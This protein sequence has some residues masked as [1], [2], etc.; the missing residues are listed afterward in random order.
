MARIMVV[1]DEP[2]TAADLEQKLVA[3]GHSVTALVDTGEE[4]VA[5]SAEQTP[6][7]VLMDIRLRTAMDGIEAARLIRARS[8]VP[9]VFLTAFADPD[10][11]DRACEA[12]PFG[13]LLKPF[14]ER[15]VATAVQVA[16]TRA[17]SERAHVERERWMAAALRGA[18]EALI[19]VDERAVIRFI[20]E[21][22]EQLL[23]V[24]Q[25][26]VLGKDARD[27]VRFLPS[28][29]GDAQHP[30][31]AALQ[32]GRMT[33]APRRGLWV[34]GR[35]GPVRV[36]YSA[37]PIRATSGAH[38]GA[39]LVCHENA[40]TETAVGPELTDPLSTLPMRLSHEINNPLTYNLGALNLALRELD[41][42]RAVSA[43]PD[44]AGGPSA[45]G[46]EDQL[47]RIE[48]LLRSAQE[49]ATRIAAV[50]RELGSSSGSARQLAPLHPVELLDLAIGLSG[51]GATPQLRVTRQLNPAPLIR[52]DK[53]ELA[54]VLAFAMQHAVDALDPDS[55][56]TNTLDLVVDCD[57]RGW[58]EIRLVARGR[59]QS[60]TTPVQPREGTL[61]ESERSTS[62]GMSMAQHVIESRGGELSVHEQPDGRVLV[63]RLEPLSIETPPSEVDAEVEPRRGSVLVVDDEPMIGRI[64]EITLQ[65]EHD[66][67]VVS[68]ASSALALLERGDAFDVILCDLSMPGMDGRELYE[69]LR[70]TKPDVAARMIFMS[71]GA[72]AE[73]GARFLE[74]MAG[75]R[76]DKPFQTEQLLQMLRERVPAH[77]PRAAHAQR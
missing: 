76:I 53:W 63:L 23:Q 57:A 43:L 20:N 72:T 59:R 44:A 65:P 19:A 49:G 71:G 51:I 26:D 42:L 48:A 61:A 13:Y 68:S 2:I 60:S 14:T 11:V 8:D 62:I 36:A 25:A 70:A 32:N 50:V 1:E 27:V 6:D 12:Q 46:L 37:A 75:C 22:A 18:G 10:T 47:V 30:L 64:L 31:D 55:S 9:I 28:D 54:R 52:G 16:L 40:T 41:Q 56:A 74:E 29:A 73:R 67:K 34:R 69:H 24:S 17:R 58:L 45:A 4:A 38:A 5:Q 33:S 35:Q 39:V 15:A 7:L 66:V 3:L 77:T 21:H